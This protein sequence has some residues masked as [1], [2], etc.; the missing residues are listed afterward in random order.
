MRIYPN[1]VFESTVLTINANQDLTVE[2][3]TLL[4]Q[5]IREPFDVRK[6]TSTNLDI[7]NLQNGPYILRSIAE[8]KSEAQLFMIQ[9]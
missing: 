4:G 8:G 9:R 5:S 1:P 6:F 3:L 2:L 7:Q